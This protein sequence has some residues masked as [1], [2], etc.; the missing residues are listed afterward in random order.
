MKNNE[1]A[2]LISILHPKTKEEYEAF[3]AMAE[4]ELGYEQQ[5]VYTCSFIINGHSTGIY[6]LN[7]YE[8]QTWEDFRDL[9]ACVEPAVTIEEKLLEEH[10]DKLDPQHPMVI[11]GRGVR[12]F[13]SEATVHV[14][15]VPVIGSMIADDSENLYDNVR[16]L[17]AGISEIESEDWED[18]EERSKEQ[19]EMDDWV[20]ENLCEPPQ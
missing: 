19:K 10:F 18:E 15:M 5:W 17:D 11:T 2:G 1:S 14:N 7:C 20:E 3:Q 16:D 8:G 12:W 6:V 4:D 9:L 13:G